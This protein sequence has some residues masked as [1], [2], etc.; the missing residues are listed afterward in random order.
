M[1]PAKSYLISNLGIKTRKFLMNET[2]NNKFSNNYVNENCLFLPVRVN[3][4]TQMIVQL[5][6][7]R[8]H[9][10]LLSSLPT[11]P[12]IPWTHILPLLGLQFLCTRQSNIDIHLNSSSNHKS[13]NMCALF[14]I[15]QH[16][17]PTLPHHMICQFDVLLIDLLLTPWINTLVPAP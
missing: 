5:P 4:P 1:H 17:F 14:G 12:H 8:E 3:L 13:K 11:L 9:Y 16:L 7:C 10:T 15:R 6:V 2:K